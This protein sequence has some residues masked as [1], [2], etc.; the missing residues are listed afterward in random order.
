M[1]FR[2]IRWE[3]AA[4]MYEKGEAFFFLPYGVLPIMVS[5]LPREQ[6]REEEVSFLAI[7]E[8]QVLRHGKTTVW[9]KEGNNDYSGDSCYRLIVEKNSAWY[10]VVGM[11]RDE[12]AA[13][14]E[15]AAY[16]YRI[17]GE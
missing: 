15:L 7:L 13:K 5:A 16:G 6:K 8:A 1:F 4:K 2:E 12:E 14:K 3:D 11:W 10:S 17:I 9:A